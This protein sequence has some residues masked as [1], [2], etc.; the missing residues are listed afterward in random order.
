MN[1]VD[2]PDMIGILGAQANDRAVLVVEPLSLLMTLRQLQAFFAPQSLDLLVIDPP[3]FHAQQFR[4]LAIAI[5]AILF[6]EA[7]QRQP[8]IIIVSGDRF[9]LVCAAGKAD[10]FA[11]PPLRRIKPLAH[12]DHRLTQIGSRQALGFK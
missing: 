8:Q 2:A 11:G 9:V 5:A 12:P 7:D 4:Y 3:A 1:E 10:R 6:S